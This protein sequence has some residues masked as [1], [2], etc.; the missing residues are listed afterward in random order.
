MSTQ[1]ATA[2][3]WCGATATDAAGF[4]TSCDRPLPRRPSQLPTLALQPEAQ[5]AQPADEQ[6]EPAMEQR[7]C[8]K[9]G[10]FSPLE[11]R[12]CPRCGLV[13]RAPPPATPPIEDTTP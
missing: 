2:C 13:F 4:C 3:P 10:Q 12:A 9:C 8:L 1:P 5:R 7:V 6:P 11:G